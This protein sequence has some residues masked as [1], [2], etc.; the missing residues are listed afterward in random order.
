[1]R[2]SF[3]TELMKFWKQ[4]LYTRLLF[5]SIIKTMT[6]IFENERTGGAI[7]NKSETFMRML[8]GTEQRGEKE[9]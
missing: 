4:Q 2:V 8:S 3:T 1:M 6:P 7:E 9:T 5:L